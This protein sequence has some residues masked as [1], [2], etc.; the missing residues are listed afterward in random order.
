[1]NT[2]VIPLEILVDIATYD[3]KTYGEMLM[4]CKQLNE[5]LNKIDAWE[6]FT[7]IDHDSAATY[8]RY[9]KLTKYRLK[10]ANLLHGKITRSYYYYPEGGEPVTQNISYYKYGVCYKQEVSRYIDHIVKVYSMSNGNKHG[11]AWKYKLDLNG[12]RTLMQRKRYRNGKR[13]NTFKEYVDKAL[14][15]SSCLCVVF[16]AYNMI[17]LAVS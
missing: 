16:V 4:L 10:N 2:C 12:S 7:Y 6:L 5:N 1:M 14:M 3:P 11:D 13:V 17:S 8:S 15:V 9:I